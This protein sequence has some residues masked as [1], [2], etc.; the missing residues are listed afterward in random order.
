MKICGEL[1]AR[2]KI[3]GLGKTRK[4]LRMQ[5]EPVGYKRQTAMLSVDFTSMSDDHH[6]NLVPAVVNFVN[7]TVIAHAKPPQIC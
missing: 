7:D 5:K 3:L 2:G 1:L 4:N 6:I